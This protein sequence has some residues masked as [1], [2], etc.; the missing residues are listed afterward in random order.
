MK[1]IRLLHLYLGC[2][3]APLLVVF[4]FTGIAQTYELHESRKDGSYVA[5]Q[6]L[7]KAAS[8]H[9]HATLAKASPSTVMRA[10]VTAMSLAL[11]AT[12]A[13]GVILAFKFGRS[14]AGV[15]VCLVL[16]VV[17]PAGLLLL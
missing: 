3:F 9:K 10:L 14:A 2:F 8:F 12:M 11:V 4:A 13:L 17:L 5:P 7:Q 1:T 6:W 16:G 15:G